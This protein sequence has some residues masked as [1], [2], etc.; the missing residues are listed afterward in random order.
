M[1]HV[2]VG[3]E[4]DLINQKKKYSYDKRSSKADLTT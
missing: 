3:F 2:Y 4:R 1:L